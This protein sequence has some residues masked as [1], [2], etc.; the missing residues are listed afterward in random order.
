MGGEEEGVG[1]K[2]TNGGEEAVMIGGT[3]RGSK[4]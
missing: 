2:R 4:E 1:K 3:V